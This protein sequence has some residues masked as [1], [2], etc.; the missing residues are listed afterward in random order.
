MP[1]AMNILW[2]YIFIENIS[3][4]SSSF[5]SVI[6]CFIHFTWVKFSLH[7]NAIYFIECDSPRS[8][9]DTHSSS[10]HPT[11]LLGVFIAEICLHHKCSNNEEFHGMGNKS[12]AEAVCVCT[13]LCDF[14]HPQL[15]LPMLLC[16][17]KPGELFVLEMLLQGIFKVWQ[18]KG[19]HFLW[20]AFAL[21][22]SYFGR[23]SYSTQF[24]LD[25]YYYLV[26]LSNT[27]YC[28]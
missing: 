26:V 4:L 19:K 27:T 5:N 22:S 17:Q 20:L 13:S 14:L 6:F 28:L 9:W 11:F 23:F 7:C 8:L 16:A 24:A 12:E 18:L 10:L 2:T 3:T 21:T 25:I 1:L 15:T